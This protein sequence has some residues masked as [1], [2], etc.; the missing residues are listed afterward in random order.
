MP[1]PH[2]MDLPQV[3]QHSTA[4]AEELG[5]DPREAGVISSPVRDQHPAFSSS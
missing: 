1:R 5:Y 3:G 4:V 2:A